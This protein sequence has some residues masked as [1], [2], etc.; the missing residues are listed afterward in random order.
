[1]ANGGWRV[2]GGGGGG[3][4]EQKRVD[5]VEGAWNSREGFCDGRRRR[6]AFWQR[7][8]D[9]DEARAHGTYARCIELLASLYSH[10]L[11]PVARDTRTRFARVY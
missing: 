9:R 5:G 4:G 3:G 6:K 8:I 10:R 7:T 1:M 2:S 11:L